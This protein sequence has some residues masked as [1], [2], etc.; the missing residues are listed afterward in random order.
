MRTDRRLADIAEQVQR[1]Y[2][3][4]D[5]SVEDI[6]RCDPKVIGAYGSGVRVRV[7]NIKSGYER[8]GVVARTSGW[9]P[10]LIL[11]HQRNAI[12]SSDVL[13]PDDRIVAVKRGNR[14]VATD[15]V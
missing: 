5:I 1:Q 4:K 10:V 13:G 2:P 7:R 11:M 9:H 12:G 15:R 14:Y 6:A 8:C 3:D